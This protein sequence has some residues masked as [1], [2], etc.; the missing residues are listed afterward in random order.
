MA[1]FRGDCPVLKALFTVLI[2]KI[3]I[4]LLAQAAIEK[5]RWAMMDHIAAK[6]VKHHRTTKLNI[7]L[8]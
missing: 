1:T 8:C 3:F 4:T 5:L 2:A 6:T 7:N